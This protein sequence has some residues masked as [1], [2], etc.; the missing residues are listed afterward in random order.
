LTTQNGRLYNGA[1]WASVGNS[2]LL[3][4]FISSDP[5]LFTARQIISERFAGD[6]TFGANTVA[7]VNKNRNALAWGQLNAPEFKNWAAPPNTNNATRYGVQLLG[8]QQFPPATVSSAYVC[9]G[10]FL[11]AFTSSLFCRHALAAP[12]LVHLTYGQHHIHGLSFR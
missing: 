4:P 11:R 8:W 12:V 9:I 10:D 3:P 2:S 1:V 5:I 7:A 6:A